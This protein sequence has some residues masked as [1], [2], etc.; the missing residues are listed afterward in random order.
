GGIGATTPGI[1]KYQPTWYG[2]ANQTT[3]MGFNEPDL[4]D[5]ANMEEETAAY[6]WPRMERFRLP[7]LGPCPSAYKGTWRQ[8]YE[9]MAEEEGL[10]SE[11][12][13]MHWYSP[14]GASTG[15]PSTLISNMET[16]YETY[17]KPIWLTE[18]STRDFDGTKTTWSRNHNYNFL[19]EFMWRAESLTWLKKWSIFEWGISGGDPAT[20]DASSD[21]PTDMNS[22][23]LSLHYNNDSDDP[24]WEDLAEC[25]LLLAGW[26]GKAEVVDETAYI[27]HNKGR[28]LRLIDHP[29]AGT[30]SHADVLNRNATEQFM[31]QTAPNGYKYIIGLSDGRRL[32][33][34]G[35]SVGLAAAGTTGTAVEWELEENQYG[36]FFINHPATSKR[37]CITT[38]NV[39][40]AYADSNTADTYQFRFIKHYLPI[41]LTEV[42][43]LPYAES[44]ENGIGAWRQ[45]YDQDKY[46][47]VGSGGTPTAAAGPSGASDGEYYL[48][49]EG[50]DAGSYV[51]NMVEC[52][53]DLA[54]YAEVEMTFD[55]HMYGSYIDFLSLDVFDGSTWTSNVWTQSGQRQSSSDAA[56]LSAVVDLSD[57]AGNAEVKLR[58]RTANKQWNAAD[59]AIDNIRL[60][61]TYQ[62]LPYAESFESGFGAW[63][64]SSDD[65]FDWTRNSGPTPTA[66]TGPDSA[67]DGSWY[68]YIEPHDDYD[69]H[70]KMAAIESIFDLSS[71]ANARLTFDYH[72][73]GVNIDYLAVDVHDGATWSSN[74]WIRS[75]AQHDSNAAAWSN[76]VVDLAAFAGNAEVTLRF[77]A[78]EGYWHVSDIAIDNIRLEE[79]L[80][81]YDLWAAVAFSNAPTGTDQSKAGN[82]DGD[83]F[84]NLQEWALVLDPLAYD[85]PA[86]DASWDDSDFTVVYA[87]RDSDE[88][89]VYASWASSLTA[90]VWRVHGDGLT[91]ET[92]ETDGEVETRSASVPIDSPQKFIRLEVS[93]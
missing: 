21:D 56:W 59:P 12:M 8:N 58:F 75:G 23:R 17:G 81:A 73:Y 43:T 72:M 32:S 66:G 85:S 48:F 79:Y 65:D 4:D 9:A 11:Y 41:S 51:T 7:L 26:D 45:F 92:L 52:G 38:G 83:R 53:F 80:S 77:R 14:N 1:L 10:R 88:V 50:H 49:S 71:V 44:F 86:L 25:G 89:S 35:S 13:A 42:Q 55:Y 28:F 84:T 33:Y 27:I 29:D 64:Q 69:G 34:D 68:L 30:V 60:E 54:P 61:G 24:G 93:E 6:Q 62:A 82:P 5:Q 40:G 74:V 3:L 76:A 18:F 47:E 78:K 37:L 91:E 67:S 39:I 20:T 22:P 46:W 19:A 31:L 70:N 36:W 90:S 57:Y 16:L 87:R 63:S 2:R 15:S